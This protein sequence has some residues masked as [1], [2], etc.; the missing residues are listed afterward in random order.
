MLN[1]NSLNDNQN[2]G[3]KEMIAAPMFNV[4]PHPSTTLSSYKKGSEM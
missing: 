4:L 3:D 1:T 2:F